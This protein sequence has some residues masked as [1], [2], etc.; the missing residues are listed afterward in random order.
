MIKNILDILQEHNL[1]KHCLAREKALE[2][3]FHHIS[4]MRYL[5]GEGDTTV[6]RYEALLNAAKALVERRID[7]V[8]GKAYICIR[9]DERSSAT[10]AL[11][12]IG[13]VTVAEATGKTDE[14][15]VAA[16]RVVVEK[17]ILDAAAAQESE[18]G[19]SAQATGEKPKGGI[20]SKIFGG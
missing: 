3:V 7:T 19:H 16:L 1:S 18:A 2:G 10:V 17:Q 14:K 13:A 6:N 20:M 11:A 9:L 12:V 15:A 5:R 8:A 4:V